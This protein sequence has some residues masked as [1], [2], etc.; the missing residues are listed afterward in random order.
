MDIGG[1]GDIHHI[2]NW[3]DQH[4]FADL[5]KMVIDKGWSAVT[6][7]KDG[8]G[9]ARG[10]WFKKVA[11]KLTPALT[12][13]NRSV[14]SIWIYN[15]ATPETKPHTPARWQL[16]EGKDIAGQGD[17]GSIKGWADKMTLDELKSYAE[18]RNWSGLTLGKAGTG[19]AGTAYFKNVAHQLTPAHTKPNPS[20]SGIWVFTRPTGAE[21]TV[22]DGA[23]WCYVTGQDIA[24]EG[25]VKK[26]DDWK[27][28]YSIADLK[29][30]V[31]DNGWSG[32]TIGKNERGCWFKKS[33]YHLTSEKTRPNPS[34][35]CIYIYSEH[36]LPDPA[37]GTWEFVADKDIA[38]QGDVGSF[39]G[40]SQKYTLDELKRYAESKGFSGFALGKD[41]TGAA[42][43]CW[44]KKVQH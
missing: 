11:Y 13:P 8:T 26:I 17:C 27:E 21:L 41:G 34:A 44:F 19:A 4:S 36:T 35:K 16:V 38:G 18:E 39:R 43:G 22:Q 7:G 23:N 24:G 29:Q 14:H 42:D 5:Q 25:D 1:E 31:V 12:R 9:A 30:M 28:H 33:F 37:P 40:W 32:F 15:G 3:S 6:L 2:S 10:A 20:A